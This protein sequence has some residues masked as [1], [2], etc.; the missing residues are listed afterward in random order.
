MSIVLYE[1]AGSDAPRLLADGTHSTAYG[2]YEFAKCI[3]DGIVDSRFDLAK[4]IV[5]GFV[6]FDPKH[7]I[8]CVPWISA[9]SSDLRDAVIS[10]S[11]RV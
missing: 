4:F 3:V 7:R 1:S 9:P 10:E 8:A 11:V 2:G 5:A 6:R